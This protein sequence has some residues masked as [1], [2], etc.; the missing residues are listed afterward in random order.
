MSPA[1]ETDLCWAEK[2]LVFDA[3]ENNTSLKAK[4]WSDEEANVIKTNNTVTTCFKNN[5][6]RCND[7]GSLYPILF[8]CMQLKIGDESNT[9][10]LLQKSDDSNLS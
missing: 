2:C 3:L 9:A 8:K 7:D 4:E 6:N 1:S 5:P 10:M